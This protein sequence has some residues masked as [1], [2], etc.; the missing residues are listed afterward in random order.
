MSSALGHIRGSPLRK[1]EG[2]GGLLC[3]GAEEKKR[4]QDRWS[5]SKKKMKDY[6]NKIKPIK[7][8]PYVDNFLD[9]I[10]NDYLLTN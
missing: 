6:Q 2:G 1:E 7:F 8:L 9:D 3:R 10:N 4:I 5:V